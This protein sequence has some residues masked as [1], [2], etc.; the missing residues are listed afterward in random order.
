MNLGLVNAT[1]LAKK[2]WD[3]SPFS[4]G[5]VWNLQ[6]TCG[7]CQT[8][9]PHQFSDPTV[10]AHLTKH[11]TSPILSHSLSQWPLLLHQNRKL[12]DYI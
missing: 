5:F 10:K 12:R 4:L 1:I 11:T 7:M 9:K 6:L 2:F 8:P 3:T